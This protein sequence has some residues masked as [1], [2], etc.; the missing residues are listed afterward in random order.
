MNTLTR[1]KAIYKSMAM[2]SVS[3]ELLEESFPIL[4]ALHKEG[5]EF[6]RETEM[7]AARKGMNR[8]NLKA[9]EKALDKKQALDRK[10]FERNFDVLQEKINKL[11]K[12]VSTAGGEEFEIIKDGVRQYAETIQITLTE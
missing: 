10:N 5:Q 1:L 6:E 2:V 8:K 12:S 9:Y 7:E 4:Q 11:V 3:A